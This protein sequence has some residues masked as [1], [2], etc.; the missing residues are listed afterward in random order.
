M[1]LPRIDASVARVLQLK[2][3][4]GLFNNPNAGTTADWEATVGSVED[5]A[6]ALQAAQESLVL[7]K[8]D[9]NALPIRSRHSNVTSGE[10]GC[11]HDYYRRMEGVGEWGGICTC[12][13]GLQFQVRKV[14][15]T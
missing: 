8:N 5:R 9:A 10:Q 14:P 2:K 11:D 3:E 13:D 6:A 12:P 7:L 1:T 15:P 4:L